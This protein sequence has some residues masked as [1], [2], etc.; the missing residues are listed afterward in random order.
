M[1][2]SCGLLVPIDQAV[3][4][5]IDYDVA[6]AAAACKK[7]LCSSRMRLVMRRLLVNS[8]ENKR[9]ML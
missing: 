7:V 3:V 1:V 6:A 8:Y 2:S 9:L 5:C 4:M